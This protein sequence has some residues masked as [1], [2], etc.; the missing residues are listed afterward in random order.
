[1]VGGVASGPKLLQILG[2]W[3]VGSGESVVAA[4]ACLRM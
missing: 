1:M 4:I 3:V 2:V